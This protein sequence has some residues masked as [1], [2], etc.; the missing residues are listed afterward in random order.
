MK[1]LLVGGAGYIGSIVNRLLQESGYQTTVLD[2]LST[3]HQ[4]SLCQNT[5]FILG[6][7]GDISILKKIFSRN[8]FSAVLHFGAK[9]LV[10]ESISNPLHYY[11]NN[12]AKTLNLLT[13]MNSAGINIFILSSTAAIFG[14]PEEIPITEKHPIRP[15]NP[16]GQSKSIIEQVLRDISLAQ[17]LRYVSLRYFN[18]AGASSDGMLGEDHKNETHLIPLI[19]KSALFP[20]PPSSA[21]KIFGTDYDTPDGTCVRDFIHVSDLAEAHLKALKYLL[22][23]GESESFNLGNGKGFSVREVILAS[24]EV[25]GK[26]IQYVESNRRQGDPPTLVSDSQYIYKKLKFKP[27]FNKL[28]DIIESAWRWHSKHPN[29]Y[30]SRGKN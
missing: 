7:F 4:E 28:E 18:A 29:G 5:N 15:I 13:E 17:G 14:N 2:D 12:V 21:L 9:S 23:G 24:N 26:T 1:V 8:S 27:K 22:N 20:P 11:H 16:Y 10:G 19:L 3:G 30:E 6:D 25:T